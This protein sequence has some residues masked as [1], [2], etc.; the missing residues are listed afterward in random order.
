M[1]LA[2]A[3]LALVQ[4]VDYDIPYLRKQQARHNQVRRAGGS[5]TTAQRSPAQRIVARCHHCVHA[6]AV[7][8][9]QLRAAPCLLVDQSV[10][11]AIYGIC[12]CMHA[13]SPDSR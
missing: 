3:G 7:T 10:W 4:A 6:T 9:R 11:S 5:C 8:A 12:A 1:W 13:C 2:E